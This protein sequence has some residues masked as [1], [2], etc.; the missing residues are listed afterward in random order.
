MIR[1]TALVHSIRLRSKEN[2]EFELDEMR[3]VRRRIVSRL[4]SMFDIDSLADE[5]A[6]LLP[7]LN[8]NSALIGLYQS[9]IVTNEPGAD[10]SIGTLIGFDRSKIIYERNI[11]RE[12]IQ[13]SE[14][15]RISDFGFEHKRRTMFLFPLFFEDEEMGVVLLPYDR[16]IHIDTYET[17]RINLSSAVKGAQMLSKIHALSVTDELTGLLNRRG[18]FQFALSRLQFLSRNPDIITVVILMDMDGL[19]HINDTYGHSEGDFALSE[20]AGVLKK[21]LREVDIIGRLGGDE[22]VVFS[23][24]RTETDDAI[25]IRRIK[26]NLDDYNNRNSHPF[27]LSTSMGSVILVEAT[28]DCLEAAIQDADSVLYTEK[29]EKR[30]QGLSRN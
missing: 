24:I 25:I 12:R 3:M 4:A 13:Y 6:R 14:I 15:S 21:T 27:K 17:L 9:N 23:Q 29:T 1:T 19:K 11:D 8:L 26:E 2:I 10:R 7:I 20:F 30:K 16:D 22:F 5:L 18:F 28:Q